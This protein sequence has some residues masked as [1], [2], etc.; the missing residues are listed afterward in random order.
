[1]AKQEFNDTGLIDTPFDGPKFSWCSGRQGIHRI[2]ARLDR[3]LVNQNFK[4]EF[5]SAS[6]SYLDRTSL[7][8][9]PMVLRCRGNSSLQFAQPFR[10]LLMWCFHKGFSPLVTQI[11]EKEVTGSP[12]VRLGRKLQTSKQA[13]KS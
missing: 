6:M 13:L 3:I 2:W 9:C 12:M 7:D 4:N 11:W 8:H 1:M 5:P 10:F